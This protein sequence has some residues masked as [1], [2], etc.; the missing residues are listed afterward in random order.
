MATGN[1]L[2][3]SNGQAAGAAI[4]SL[5]T[6]YKNDG[7]IDVT[8][9]NN[10]VNMVSLANGIQGLKG[11]DDKSAF[12]KDFATGLILGSN[13]LITNNNSSAITGLLGGLASL[14]GIATGALNN[15]VSS[16][17][18]GTQNALSAISD[19]TAGVASTVSTLSSIFNMLN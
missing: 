14:T 8:N 9:M 18:S 7:K 4:R 12:Y 1:S 5:Y 19:K 15:M 2:G 13:N 17:A 6:Q 3:S 16:A 11:L 10:V